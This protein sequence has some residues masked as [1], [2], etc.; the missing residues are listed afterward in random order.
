[1]SVINTKRKFV[2]IWV[3]KNAGSTI[4]RKMREYEVEAGTPGDHT[5]LSALNMAYG[6]LD[7]Y[8]KWAFVR[9]PYTR[10][11]SAYFHVIN[12][13]MFHHYKSFDEFLLNDFYDKKGELSLENSKIKTHSS[14]GDITHFRPQTFFLQNKEGEVE[15]DFL[16]RVENMDQDW[17]SLCTTLGFPYEDLLVHNSSYHQEGTFFDKPTDPPDPA[18]ADVNNYWV[19]FEGPESKSKIEIVNEL[20]QDDFKQF[21]YTKL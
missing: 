6:P 8:Y 7:D 1:M 16:G 12:A 9:N 18:T 11:A 19:H 4:Y 21:G 10:L 15:F 14:L 13:H 5:P 17:A 3:P 20:Y 2:W